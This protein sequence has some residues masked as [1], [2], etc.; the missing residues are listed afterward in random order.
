MY[1][2]VKLLAM[3]Q[4]EWKLTSAASQGRPLLRAEV[5]TLCKSNCF[6]TELRSSSCG[7]H[8]APDEISNL[9]QFTR[10]MESGFQKA[11]LSL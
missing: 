7:L 10:G 11:N 2:S 9:Y 6:I 5:V 4:T 1:F 8:F 3:L